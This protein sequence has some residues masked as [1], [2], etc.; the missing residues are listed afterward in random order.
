MHWVCVSHQV[1]LVVQPVGATV[2]FWRVT[3]KVYSS[4]PNARGDS[5]TSAMFNYVLSQRAQSATQS[6]PVDGANLQLLVAVK[7]PELDSVQR[8]CS[9]FQP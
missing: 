2:A 3:F 8:Q 9:R 7:T 1:I 6:S 4:I 5:V